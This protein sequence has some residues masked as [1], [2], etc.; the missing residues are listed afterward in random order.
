MILLCPTPTTH[1]DYWY[2]CNHAW[3]FMWDL[4]ILTR[5]LMLLRQVIQA[6]EPSLRSPASLMMPCCPLLRALP[7]LSWPSHSLPWIPPAHTDY[8]SQACLVSLILLLQLTTQLSDRVASYLRLSHAPWKLLRGL[9][10]ASVDPHLLPPPSRLSGSLAL[11][12]SWFG[13]PSSPSSANIDF[14]PPWGSGGGTPI[15]DL[16]CG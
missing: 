16:S 5:G 6:T 3:F 15:S 12:D 7:P 13:L 10:A 1:W 9:L 4:G 14:F 11:L 2:R 8:P